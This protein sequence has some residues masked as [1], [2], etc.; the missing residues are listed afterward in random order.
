M[1]S[2]SWLCE[3]SDVSSVDEPNSPAEGTRVPGPHS[4]T[5][6]FLWRG[7]HSKASGQDTAA[8]LS[9][10]VNGHEESQVLNQ[11]WQTTWL[12]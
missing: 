8:F 2:Y 9:I 7:R 5:A 10:G 1:M 6:L 11:T 3:F 12:C 4:N